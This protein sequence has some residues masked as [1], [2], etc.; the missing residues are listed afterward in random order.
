M[1][2]TFNNIEFL[3]IYDNDWYLF[4]GLVQEKTEEVERAEPDTAATADTA[5]SARWPRVT[6]LTEEARR[7]AC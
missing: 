2:I 7:R 1:Y 3:L 6:K 4:T 5:D